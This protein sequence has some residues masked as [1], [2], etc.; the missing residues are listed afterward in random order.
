MGELVGFKKLVRCFKTA[1]LTPLGIFY[2]RWVAA[3]HKTIRGR[4]GCTV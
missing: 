3:P 2:T 4:R 1:H